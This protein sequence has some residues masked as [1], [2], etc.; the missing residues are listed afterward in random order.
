[1][2]F[3]EDM[4]AKVCHY[5]YFDQLTMSDIGARLGMSRHKVGRI[6]NGA[7]QSGL[8]KIEI[9]HP[10][11]KS[12][13]LE[14]ELISRFGLKSAIVATF[15]EDLPADELKQRVGAA[16]ANFVASVI[17]DGD[18]VGIGWGTTTFE[19]ANQISAVG[20]KSVKVVQITGGNGA[21]SARFGC[22]DVT[23]VFAKN[24]GVEPVLLHA[25]GIVGSKNMRDL[26]L[27]EQM[28]R[29]ATQYFPRLSLAVVGIGTLQPRRSALVDSG[30]IP[31][32]I[33][34]E[35]EGRGGVG[36]IYSCFI[37]AEGNIIDTVLNER[38]VAIG[39]EDIKRIPRSIAVATG[40]SKANAVRA[41]MRAKLTNVLVVDE[42][43]AEA[44]L[45]LD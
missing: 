41:V 12:V 4:A 1:M 18:V 10:I 9:R 2:S 37:D 29:E 19:V 25:P 40:A 23:R 39:I 15:P 32:S 30:I 36:D 8:V 17:D 42:K 26:L 43:L 21:V 13:S 35:I 24:I 6:L 38:M 45:R 11:S 14:R 5:Y 22:Q 33:L 3:D 34:A 27:E 20:A 7:L 28:I 16:A 44:V 31:A